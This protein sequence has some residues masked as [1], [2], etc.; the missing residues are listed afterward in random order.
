MVSTSVPCRAVC[1]APFW[2]SRLASCTSTLMSLHG[3]D[4]V[5]IPLFFKKGKYVV[6]VHDVLPLILPQM[7]TLKH[8][9]VVTTALARVSKQADLVIVPSQVVK[10]DVVHY[11]RVGEDR[12]VVIPE[13][14]EARFRPIGDP[15]RLSQVHVKYAFPPGTSCS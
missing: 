7:F 12:I 10:Q 15:A 3:L 4:H 8:R 11:L 9:F 6:T 2:P 14:C 5:E 1:C 13:G